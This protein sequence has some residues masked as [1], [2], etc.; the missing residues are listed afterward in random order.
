[1]EFN[2]SQ[3][4]YLKI[5]NILKKHIVCSGTGK[6]QHL[7][8]VLSGHKLL[9]TSVCTSTLGGVR[10]VSGRL[11]THTCSAHAEMNSA[12]SFI[13]RKAKARLTMVVI[14]CRH[15]PQG[16]IDLMMS[17]PCERCTKALAELGVRW[18]IFSVP[19][20]LRRCKPI[21]LRCE[22]IPSFADKTPYPTF[23][24]KEE[25]HKRILAGDKKVDLR[26]PRGFVTS[27][28]VGQIL[29][30][31][32]GSGES[33][34][35]KITRIQKY[36]PSRKGVHALVTHVIKREGLSIVLPHCKSI[37]QGVR[38]LLHGTEEQEGALKWRSVSRLGLWAIEL[39]I[40]F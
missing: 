28:Y 15:T 13:Y 20:G 38:Y 37:P 5:E 3:A 14:R 21:Q 6:F 11:L 4:L 12:K 17:R 25:A 29:N 1:M 26:V 22:S 7:S 35:A 23:Y 24:V 33:R 40:N 19:D 2:P 10:N 9:P 36:S 16:D 34:P 30:V 31:S 18:V 32:S 27:L 8:F 39:D